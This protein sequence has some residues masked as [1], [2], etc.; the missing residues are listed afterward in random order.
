[1]PP[2]PRQSIAPRSCSCSS[3]RARRDQRRRAGRGR[4]LP[5]STVS[6][7]VSALER[8]GLVQRQ[9]RR[10]A[11]SAPAR[12]CCGWPAAA[13]GRTTSS[14]CAATALRRLAT[15]PARRSTWRSPCRAGSSTT[16]PR[17]TAATSWAPPT[18]WGAAC[19]TTATAV[20]KVLVAFGA[21]HPPRRRAAPLHG[22]HHHRSRPLRGAA[23]YGARTRLRDHRGRAGDRPGGGGRARARPRRPGRGRAL[24]LGPAV[25]DTERSAGP[26]WANC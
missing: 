16:S 10:A 4:G 6:R 17:S 13:W 9:E 7:L 11:R 14:S 12:C 21:A 1:M 5:K 24:D 20:G 18:G 8:Q 19:P 26:G 2:E 3:S 22:R 25:P 15:P 23:G